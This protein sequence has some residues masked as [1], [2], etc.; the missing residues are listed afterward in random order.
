MSLI[1]P[2]TGRYLAPDNPK[3]NLKENIYQKQTLKFNGQI[4]LSQ[5]SNGLTWCDIAYI[6]SVYY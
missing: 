1:F 4:K 2:C 6:K 5:K 3:N